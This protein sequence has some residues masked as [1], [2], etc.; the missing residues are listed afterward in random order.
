MKELKLIPPSDPR[1]NNAIAP[2]VDEMLKDEG[3][4]TLRGYKLHDETKNYR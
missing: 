3:I 4:K 1:V 2:F